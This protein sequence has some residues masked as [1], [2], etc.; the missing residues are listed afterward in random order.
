MTKCK[1]YQEKIINSNIKA[2]D[3]KI[4]EKQQLINQIKEESKE[5]LIPTLKEKTNEL[6]NYII[7]LLKN[8]GAE[9]VNNIQIMSLIAQR[10]MLEVANVGNITYTPQ[11]I[12]LGFN[13]YLEMINKINEIKKFPPTVESFSIFM[14]ISRTTYNNWLVDP[15]KREV[16]DYIHSYLLGVLATGGLMG[17]VREI[18]AMY[19]QKTM[20]KVEAQQPIVVK[21]EK[22][23]DIND[24]NKQLEAL[25]RDNIIE[26]EFEE[27]EK[28]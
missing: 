25:K 14:G 19:L 15:D 24:I 3:K 1:E 22:V 4:R 23:T 6:T 21:H 9:K 10:S 8:K 2:R 20:G 28:D 7:E 16:M 26:A 5:K 13:L 18:S 12:M 11:E 27:V 17:E